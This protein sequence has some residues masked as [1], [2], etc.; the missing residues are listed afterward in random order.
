MKIFS[1]TICC[2]FVLLIMFFGSQNILSIR[3]SHLLIIALC[4]CATGVIFRKWS[5]VRM[6]SNILPT[7]SF[8]VIHCGWF[9]AVC[10]FLFYM[11]LSMFLRAVK[12]FAEIYTGMVLNQLIALERLSFLLY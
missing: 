11:K 7:F 10:F 4:V 9:Y 1:H 2:L 8:S 12:I 3:R 5:P 6:S